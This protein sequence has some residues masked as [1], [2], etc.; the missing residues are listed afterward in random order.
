MSR[1]LRC[2]DVARSTAGPKFAQQASSALS[3]PVMPLI[4]APPGVR[5]GGSST[6][7]DDVGSGEGSGRPL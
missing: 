1:L 3:L 6:P 2:T 5:V 4:T 7:L